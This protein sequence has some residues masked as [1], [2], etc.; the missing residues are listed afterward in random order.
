ML[1]L[2]GYYE[3]DVGQSFILSSSHVF[4]IVI[5]ELK[6]SLVLR[7]TNRCLCT[8]LCKREYSIA[9]FLVWCYFFFFF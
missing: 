6:I 5:I 2:L 8:A 7:L 3:Y 4:F 9:V 1:L